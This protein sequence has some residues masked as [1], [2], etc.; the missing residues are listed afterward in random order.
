M[1]EDMAKVLVERPRIG[2]GNRHI[3]SRMAR[4]KARNISIDN[5][6]NFDSK[7]SMKSHLRGH[8]KSE[9]CKKQ[10]NENL[11]PLERYLLSNV[12]RCWD[13]IYSDIMAGINLNSAV[14]YHVWQHLIPMD[15]VLTKTFLNEDRKVYCHNWAGECVPIE[16]HHC[17]FY[18]HPGN[19]TLCH[20]P[21]KSYRQVKVALDRWI[22]EQNPL[23]QWHKIDGIWY[24]IELREALPKEIEN[25]SFG[26]ARLTYD[27]NLCKSVWTWAKIWTNKYVDQI[28]KSSKFSHYYFG[29]RLWDLCN[30]LFDGRRLPV[31]KRQAN[32]KQ[33]RWIEEKIAQKVKKNK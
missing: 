2:S 5:G 4:R 25:K 12:G 23:K 7:Q 6:D 20:K 15:M 1:R 27:S 16:E 21:R 29:D 33:V 3:A 13:D 26:E 22:N 8:C 11:R 28:Y 30:R 31:K 24:E 32:K 9:F 10:L 17:D 19:G 18:V 14:Q